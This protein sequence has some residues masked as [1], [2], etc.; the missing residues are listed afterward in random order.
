M[1]LALFRNDAA[2]AEKW[3]GQVRFYDLPNKTPYETDKKAVDQ[4]DAKNPADLFRVH[5]LLR[6]G[7]IERG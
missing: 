6:R 2:E 4:T 3:S 5:L 1:T 7:L